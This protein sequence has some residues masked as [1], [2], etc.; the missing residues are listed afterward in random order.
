MTPIAGKLPE[1]RAGQA[2]AV[3][4]PVC[5]LLAVIFGVVQPA[6]QGYCGRQAQLA[7]ARQQIAQTLAQQK[8]LPQLRRQ[9]Q[10]AT[11]AFGK[12]QILLAGNLD[13]VAQ[14]NL[15]SALTV[16]AAGSGV[17]LTSTEVLPAAVSDAVL[18]R[19]A[20]AVNVTGDWP[21]LTD[22][23]ASIETARPRMI[24]DDLSIGGSGGAD[25]LLQ[26]RFVVFAFRRGAPQ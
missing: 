1:G 3:A 25:R 5:L 16:L 9:A 17:S 20:I 2:L 18:Q 23:L 6:L 7:Q 8:I 21:A 11:D 26:A 10:A 15:Q 14:A 12:S 22:F 24:V 19:E 4:A 13:A